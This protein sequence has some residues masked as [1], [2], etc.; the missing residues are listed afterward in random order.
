MKKEIVFKK[1][2]WDPSQWNYVTTARHPEVINFLQ[3]DNFISNTFD[4]NNDPQYISMLYKENKK[5]IFTVSTKCLFKSYGAPLIV[6]ADE[7][8]RLENGV[9]RYNEY[10]E[11]VL[12]C[13][14]IN[15]WYIDGKNRTI[16]QIVREEFPV[17][18]NIARTLTVTV[19]TNKYTLTIELDGEKN[20]HIIP[21]D[22]LSKFKKFYVGITACEGINNFYNFNIE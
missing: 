20:K 17:E 3:D 16:S 15:L 2:S 4:D 22:K 1:G 9:L 21:F 10:V 18:E 14:G 12:Y 6:I 7:P 5:G 13:N 19:D 8:T 11:V